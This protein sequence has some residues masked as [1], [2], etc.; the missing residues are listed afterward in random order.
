MLG[1]RPKREEEPPA[2]IAPKEQI[3]M[4]KLAELEEASETEV[5]PIEKGMGKLITSG[6][7][8]HGFESNFPQQLALGDHIILMTVTEE[9]KLVERERRRVNMVLSAKSCGLEEP[10]TEDLIN[11]SEY[12]VQRKPKLK[13]KAKPLEEVVRDRMRQEEATK[14]SRREEV[15]ESREAMLD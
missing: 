12:Y 4:A 14:R 10:F 1:K 2:A 6:R 7:T 5:H 3:S 8:V 15:E 13:E 11:K 9:G